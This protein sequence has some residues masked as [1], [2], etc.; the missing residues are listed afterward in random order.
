MRE[1]CRRKRLESLVE[2][3]ACARQGFEAPGGLEIELGELHA[4]ILHG[5]ASRRAKEAHERSAEFPPAGVRRAPGVVEVDQTE[6]AVLESEDVVQAEVGQE[7]S[8]GH[9]SPE[10]D[11]DMRKGLSQESGLELAQGPPFVGS[12]EQERA[13]LASAL[14]FLAPG[15]DARRGEARF[16]QR[17]DDRAL[18]PGLALRT[19]LLPA[20]APVILALNAV[21]ALEVAC[22]LAEVDEL[23]VA[24]SVFVDDISA[25]AIPGFLEG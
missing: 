6:A 19:R 3:A 14:D 12:G 17:V 18:S 9:R 25:P 23:D 20:Q 5:F 2:E 24:H 16:V 13:L 10:F 8:R 11:R 15:E 1:S 22:L 7:D 4:Q 21:K